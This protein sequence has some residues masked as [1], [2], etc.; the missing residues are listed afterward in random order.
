MSDIKTGC[1]YR[2]RNQHSYEGLVNV[3]SVMMPIAWRILRLKELS[4]INPTAPATVLFTKDECD[5]L[6]VFGPEDLPISPTISDFFFCLARYGGFIKQKN[7][8]PGW[9]ILCRALLS[10]NDKVAGCEAV[11]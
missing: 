9:L 5:V 4:Q 6:R 2:L 7:S 10:L 3:I 8:H 11:K 1:G